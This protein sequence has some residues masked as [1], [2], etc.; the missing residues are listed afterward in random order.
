MQHQCFVT[1]NPLSAITDMFFLLCS[2]GNN[3]E[4]RVSSGSDIEPTNAGDAKVMAPFGVIPISVV[5]LF[6]VAP[7]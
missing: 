7:S 1:V 2:L 3:P 4:E 6:V 5:M